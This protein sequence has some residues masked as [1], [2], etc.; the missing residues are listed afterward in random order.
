MANNKLFWIGGVSHHFPLDVL[1]M[2]WYDLVEQASLV[3]D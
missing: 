2:Q 3:T 1:A